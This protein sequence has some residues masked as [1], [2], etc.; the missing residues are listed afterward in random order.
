VKTGT[1]KK[2]IEKPDTFAFEILRGSVTSGVQR[3][4]ERDDGPGHPRHLASKE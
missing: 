4:G 2:E 1:L 3:G